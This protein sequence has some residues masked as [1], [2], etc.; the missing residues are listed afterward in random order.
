MSDLRGVIIA[1]E[2][3]VLLL[4]SFADVVSGQFLGAAI[5]LGIASLAAVCAWA[6]WPRDQIIGLAGEGPRTAGSSRRLRR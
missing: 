5:L 4:V 2:A 1:A 3:V 6:L